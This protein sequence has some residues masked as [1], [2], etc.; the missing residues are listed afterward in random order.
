[1]TQQE[2]NKD[3]RSKRKVGG[4]MEQTFPLARKRGSTQLGS[5]TWEIKRDIHAE[6]K[7]RKVGRDCNSV[8]EPSPSM[9]EALESNPTQTFIN[10]HSHTH[11]LTYTHT[12]SHTHTLT[13][14]HTHSHILTHTH[15]HTYILY[16][17]TYT[18]TCT[19]T[20]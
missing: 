4:D 6:I 13:Y 11:T 8:T 12:H 15:S 16:T 19:H 2:G 17:S 18:L 9:C 10:I 14:T 5:H 7:I 20:H 1:M 3:G